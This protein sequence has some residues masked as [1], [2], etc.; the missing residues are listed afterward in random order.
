MIAT[1]LFETWC[2]FK[3]DFRD[4]LILDGLE[5][6]RRLLTQKVDE[7]KSVVDQSNNAGN[8]H[9]SN[10]KE[11]KVADA[12]KEDGQAAGDKSGGPSGENILSAPSSRNDAGDKSGE[13]GGDKG[14]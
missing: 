14:N 2:E 12:P 4:N 13:K 11:A 8:G 9:G 10:S 5:S 1:P 6:N 3:P 7:T